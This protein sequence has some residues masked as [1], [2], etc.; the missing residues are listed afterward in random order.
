M[1]KGVPSPADLGS[2][3]RRKLPGGI[4]GGFG[5]ILEVT[6]R[7]FMYLYDKI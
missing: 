5:R 7:F 1:G 4:R 2:G 6:E 3:E